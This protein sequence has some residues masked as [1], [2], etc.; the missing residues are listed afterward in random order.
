MT[1]QEVI[2]YSYRFN[3]G[4]WY[5]KWYYGLSDEQRFVFLVGAVFI[6]FAIGMGGRPKPPK[7]TG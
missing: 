2:E 1:P 7:V 6:M 5:D 3:P 4:W